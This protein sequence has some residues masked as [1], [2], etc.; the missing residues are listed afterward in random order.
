MRDIA[1]RLQAAGQTSPSTDT[2]RRYDPGE[3]RC[4]STPRGADFDHRDGAQLLRAW[5]GRPVVAHRAG[6]YSADEH[7]LEALKRNGVG[8]D[9]SPFWG[10][11]SY[12]L[13]RL[14]LPHNLPSLLGPLT[15][16]PVTVYRREERPGIFGTA[17]APVTTVRKIDANWFTTEDEMRASIEAAVA[18]DLPV[19][20]VFLHSFSFMGERTDGAPKPTA[21][22][23][24]VPSM[25]DHIALKQ[26]PVVTM[27]EIDEGTA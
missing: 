7:T 3:P 10:H 15:E 14:A 25:L 8:I 20:V 1:V 17:F 13:N 27:R 5:T 19:L 2:R 22:G 12:R 4:A 21:T 24:H 23:G 11:S 6:D 18:S 26:L 9:S 16:I